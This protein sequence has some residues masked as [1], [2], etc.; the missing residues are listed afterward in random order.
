MIFFSAH[1]TQQLVINLL[2]KNRQEDLWGSGTPGPVTSFRTKEQLSE[3]IDLVCAYA[4]EDAKLSEIEI[5]TGGND[6]SLL[7]NHKRSLRIFA[8][9]NNGTNIRLSSLGGGLSSAKTLRVEVANASG[10]VTCLAFAKLDVIPKIEDEFRRYKDHIAPIL[11]S[12]F[13]AEIRYL[14]YGSGSIG[15]I[16]YQFAEGFDRSLFDLL[17]SDVDGA[18]SVIDALRALQERWYQGSEIETLSISELR[19]TLVANHVLEPYT[20]RLETGWESLEQLRISV[21]VCSQHRDLHPLN[22]LVK[23]SLEPLMIDYGDV[24]RGA[25][26]TDPITLEFSLIFHPGCDHLLNGWPTEAQASEWTNLNT[27]LEGCPIASY[28]RACRAWA[29]KVQGSDLAVFA[30]VYS[31]CVRQ[32]KYPN[33]NHTL[34][35][36]FANCALRRLQESK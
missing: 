30:M 11:L 19:Q 8:R 22:L 34:A 33:T 3:C 4:S 18:A 28:I 12:G 23:N 5:S 1:G 31:Y 15:G 32:L 14:L 16:Y 24:K 29:F 26:C 35:L 21:R 20:G 27:Y 10:G 36:A 7:Y 6:L 2:E 13:T 25:A 9:L 17:K